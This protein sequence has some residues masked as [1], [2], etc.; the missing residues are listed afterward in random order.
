MGRAVTASPLTTQEGVG[1][2]WDPKNLVDFKEKR[3]VSFRKE[4]RWSEKRKLEA[5]TVPPGLAVSQE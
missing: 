1:T 5:Y 3:A 2:A 4:D